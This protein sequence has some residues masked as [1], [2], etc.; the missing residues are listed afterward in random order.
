MKYFEMV[1]NI[2]RQIP[3]GKVTNYGTIARLVG[4][5]NSSRIVGYALH[6]NPD[7]SVIPCHRV[8][9]KDGSLAASFA[10]GGI[11]AQ[12]AMLEAEGVMVIDYKVDMS[13]YGWNTGFKLKN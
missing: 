8:V 7:N 10:F 12:K 6:S 4:R 1:Y 3:K 9:M 11:D 5:P 2:V 13:K